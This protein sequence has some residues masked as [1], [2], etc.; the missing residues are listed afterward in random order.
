MG[1]ISRTVIAYPSGTPEFFAGFLLLN[2]MN[3]M[4]Y[5]NRVGHWYTQINTYKTWN[6]YHTNRSNNE[7][8]NSMG[9]I[10]RTV[11]AYPSGTPEF[12]AG[13]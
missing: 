1:V 11:I 4:W 9:V 13:F 3:M 7:P 10:S 8:S 5:W 12:F 6:L 2:D